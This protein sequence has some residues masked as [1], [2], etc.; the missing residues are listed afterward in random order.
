MNDI[1]ALLRGFDAEP[2]AQL[3]PAET[4]RSERLL[5]QITRCAQAAPARHA[6]ARPAVVLRPARARRTLWTAGVAAAAL[7]FGVAAG[8]QFA[9]HTA[10]RQTGG[11]QGPYGLTSAELAAWTATPAHPALTSPVVQRAADACLASFPT[12][13]AAR[14]TDISDVDQRGSVITL[15]ATDPASRTTVWCMTASG[16]PVYTQIAN[17]PQWHPMAAIGASAVNAQSYGWDGSGRDEISFAYGQA[18]ADVTGLSLETPAG[19]T[20]T[21]T[22]QNGVW[23]LW[24]PPRDSSTGD[25]NATATWTTAGGATYSAPLTS[26]SAFKKK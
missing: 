24:W 8:S 15:M 20:I 14:A 4:A 1:D 3:T 12:L 16:H 11:A 9:G 21:A 5:A 26:L 25:L 17:S 2:G 18:G 13:G 22:V 6:A 7:A 19:E 23:S 10:G